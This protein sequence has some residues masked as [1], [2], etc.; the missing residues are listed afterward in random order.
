MSPNFQNSNQSWLEIPSEN[1]SVSSSSSSILG[2]YSN[3]EKKAKLFYCLQFMCLSIILS[4]HYS[5]WVIFH[6]IYMFR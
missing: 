3:W 2:L 5:N 6:I 1:R 4:P